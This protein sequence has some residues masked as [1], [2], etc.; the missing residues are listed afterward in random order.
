MIELIFILLAG[1]AIS[2]F[3]RSW[4]FIKKK[5]VL[6]LFLLLLCIGTHPGITNFIV[7]HSAAISL[8]MVLGIC[9]FIVSLFTLDKKQTNFDR[10]LTINL[11]ITA[12]YAAIISS[13]IN[14]T[15]YL[16]YY[17]TAI[18]YYTSISYLVV[19]AFFIYRFYAKE[20][21]ITNN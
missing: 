21:L 16:G 3:I 12:I 20:K 4:F 13:L 14:F 1:L 19:T 11:A 9:S 6:S 10:L 2:F 17:G 15:Y 18:I 5:K 7:G 8:S